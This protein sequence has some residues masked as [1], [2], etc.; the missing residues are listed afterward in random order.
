[1]RAR[2]TVTVARRRPQRRPAVARR[3]ERGPRP[4]I[5]LVGAYDL[6]GGDEPGEREAVGHALAEG[7]DVGL[8]AVVLG[9]EHGPGA[10]EAGDH[11][12]EDQ[13]RVELARHR[14]HRRQPVGRWDHV[15]RRPLDG[16]DDDGG[17]RT[18]GVEPDELPQEVDAG[19]AARRVLELERAAVAVGIGRQVVADRQRPELVLELAAHQAEHARGLAVEAAPESHHLVLL[20]V[21]PRQAQGALDG[22]GAARVELGALERGIGRDLRQALQQLEARLAG[23]RTGG[24]PLRLLAEGV[25]QRRVAMAERGHADA[26][27]EIDE[28][29]AVDVHQQRALAVVHG[30]TGQLRQRLRARRQVG[31][32]G[33][34]DGA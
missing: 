12:I 34:D 25:R 2:V 5:A 23:E 6:V 19:E 30:D 27:H 18:G 3:R 8:D 7:H 33:V 11:L 32:L 28:G 26:G 21:G 9:A 24:D 22:L 20:G 15:A 1:M 13:Q 16:L 29:V 31:P 17:Q 10:A 4:R 14:L